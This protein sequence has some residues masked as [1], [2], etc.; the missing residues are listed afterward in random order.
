MGEDCD[1]SELLKRFVISLGRVFFLLMS[2]LFMKQL[3][4]TAQKN[5]VALMMPDN[6]RCCVLS[7]MLFF[8]MVRLA[9]FV[10]HSTGGMQV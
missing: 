3:N 10:A 1:S 6:W 4:A 8:S 7:E 2:L 9:A 5:G